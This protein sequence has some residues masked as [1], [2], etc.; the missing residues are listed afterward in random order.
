MNGALSDLNDND[1][2]KMTKI[3]KFFNYLPLNISIS[4]L[5]LMG[6]LFNQV[7]EC[8]IMAAILS[9]GNFSNL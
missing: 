4:R 7:E 5:I 2:I 1:K 6:Y 3:G 9:I 8:T